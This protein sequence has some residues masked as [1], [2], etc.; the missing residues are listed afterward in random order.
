MPSSMAAARGASLCG[1]LHPHND[2]PLAAAMLDGILNQIGQRP[3]QRSRIAPHLDVLDST[4]E[5]YFVAG[6]DRKRSKFGGHFPADGYD[7]DGR[8]PV[9]LLVDALQVQ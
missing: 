1:R 6:G 3:L 9:G 2:A 4:V 8:K 5:R 7:I